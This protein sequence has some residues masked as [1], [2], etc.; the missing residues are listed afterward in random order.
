VVGALPPTNTGV[1]VRA[2]LPEALLVNRLCE[3]VHAEQPLP[4][5][6]ALTRTLSRTMMLRLGL[7]SP[8]TT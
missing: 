8:L 6:D 3:T 2:L 5:S 7:L 1:P 4:F